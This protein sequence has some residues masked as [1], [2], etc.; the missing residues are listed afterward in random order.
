[1]AA[2][3]N[4]LGSDMRPVELVGYLASALV[5]ATFCVK[6]MMPLRFIAIASNV[7]FMIYGYLGGMMPILLLHA[8][9]LPLNAGRL[10]QALRSENKLQRVAEQARLS[11]KFLR[12]RNVTRPRTGAPATNA[13]DHPRPP[14]LHRHL[15]RRA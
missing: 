8:V 13:T 15:P 9:L 12:L 4:W 5:F 14:C 6:A 11:A 3:Q 1:M 2:P 7:A 10:S